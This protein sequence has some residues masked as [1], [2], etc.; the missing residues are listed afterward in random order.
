[1]FTSHIALRVAQVKLVKHRV[2]DSDTLHLVRLLST[3]VFKKRLT[4]VFLYI[5]FF[6]Y[7]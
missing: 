6:V 4:L 7:S 5:Y 2:S 1:M 3:L